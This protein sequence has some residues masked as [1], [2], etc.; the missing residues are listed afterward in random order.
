MQLKRSTKFGE[1]LFE[2]KV[3]QTFHNQDNVTF[4]GLTFTVDSQKFRITY[5]E[6]N[7]ESINL[8]IQAIIRVMDSE[9]ISGQAYRLISAIGHDLPREWAVSNMRQ[10]INQQM[11]ELIPIH[12]IDLNLSQEVCNEDDK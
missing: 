3:T 8:Q 10:Q 6:I 12:L 4:E 11:K 7:T 9:K 2:Q 5:K 1:D